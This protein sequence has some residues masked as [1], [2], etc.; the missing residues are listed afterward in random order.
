MPTCCAIS[1]NSCWL[2]WN[3]I[4]SCTFVRVES[5]LEVIV[6]SDRDV[7]FTFEVFGDTGDISM[8][9]SFLVKAI[10]V[11]LLSSEICAFLEFDE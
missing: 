5:D 7:G 1:A 11:F 10:A 8:S 6:F 9:C 3:A 2:A 4:G